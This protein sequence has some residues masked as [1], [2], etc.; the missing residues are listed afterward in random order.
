MMVF[1]WVNTGSVCHIL[2]QMY[3][4][5]WHRPCKILASNIDFEQ[6]RFV[7]Y[8]KVTTILLNLDRS[9]YQ[10]CTYICIKKRCLDDY[11]MFVF[12]RESHHILDWMVFL[13]MRKRIKNCWYNISFWKPPV[14]TAKL[15]PSPYCFRVIFL[16]LK[17][18]SAKYPGA[19]STFLW[20]K[21]GW[22][23]HHVK[24]VKKP[25]HVNC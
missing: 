19:R 15:L 8:N 24:A 21:F 6:S 1:F 11:D 4:Q 10:K 17:E 9:P 3:W 12:Y 5:W 25:I 14:Q 2:A 22:K 23:W 7:K 13:G 16:L 18:T 20:V